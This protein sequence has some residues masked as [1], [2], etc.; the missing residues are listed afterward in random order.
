MKNLKQQVYMS[1]G[2]LIITVFLV[3]V[4]MFKEGYF[5]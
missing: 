1:I 4:A 2:I 3:V 5:A